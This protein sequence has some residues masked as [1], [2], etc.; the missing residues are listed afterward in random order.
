MT[1]KTKFVLCD[2]DRDHLLETLKNPPPP[3]EKLKNLFKEYEERIESHE[4]D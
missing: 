3:N 1:E 4:K 2:E